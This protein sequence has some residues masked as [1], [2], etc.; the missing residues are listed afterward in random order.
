VKIP[1]DFRIYPFAAQIYLEEDRET[2]SI[3]ASKTPGFPGTAYF[4]VTTT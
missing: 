1:E 2:K 3:M 4:G